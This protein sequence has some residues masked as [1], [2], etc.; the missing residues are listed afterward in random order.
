MLELQPCPPVPSWHLER[1]PA[2]GKGRSMLPR[3]A[4]R[5]RIGGPVYVDERI[6]EKLV[7]AHLR[8]GFAAAF[9]PD[10]EDPALLEEIKAAYREADIV[11]AETGAFVINML[12]PDEERRQANIDLICRRLERA[13]RVGSL[14]CVAHGGSPNPRNLLAHNPENFSRAT[15][16]GIVEAVQQIIDR[17]EPTS[18]RFVLE[19]ESRILPDSPDIYLEILEA[20]DRS[21]FA[22]HLDPINITSS[23]RRFYFS[24]EFIRDCFS[25]LGPWI[26]SSHAKDIQMVPGA[27]VRFEETFCGNG[28]IDFDSY[29]TELVRLESDVPLMIEHVTPRQLPW[30]RA[31]LFQRAEAVGV[32]IRNGE[33]RGA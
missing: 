20:V 2:F 32:E 21:A 9:D 7:E 11:I 4:N 22:V 27:Q 18:T 3:T 10:V 6:P 5:L 17:V 30:A 8:S 13:D 33:Y 23:P 15:F 28:G 25:K 24:G 29:I 1:T 31:Y 12:D 26:V 19:T 14:C 16:A